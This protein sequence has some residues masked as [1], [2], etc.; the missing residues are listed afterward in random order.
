MPHDVSQALF[1]SPSI[2][3]PIF[4]RSSNGCSRLGVNAIRVSSRFFDEC[5]MRDIEDWL[6]VINDNPVF[7]LSQSA[8]R[9]VEVAPLKLDV[10][11]SRLLIWG[12]EVGVSQQALRTRNSSTCVWLVIQKILSQVE[13]LLTDSERL[14]TS[15]GIRTLETP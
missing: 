7:R 6:D 5:E 3:C 12:S 11:K 13:S 14:R 1:Q 8:D 2:N 15:Y 10:E 4:R 9:G